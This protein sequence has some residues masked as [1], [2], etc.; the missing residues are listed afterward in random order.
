[1]F[2]LVIV[3]D[4]YEL[5]NGLR[6]Y[7]PWEEIGFAVG[8]VCGSGMAALEYIMHNQV[9]VLFTDIK[10]PQMDGIELIEKVKKISPA[11]RSVIISG[12][13]DF[14]YARKGMALGVSDFIVKPAKYAEIKQVFSQIAKEL[15]TREKFVTEPVVESGNR[16]IDA[17][18][19]Y[20]NA[21][22]HEA[23][24]ETAAMQVR[25]NPYYLSTLFHQITKEKFSACL[26]RIR[27]EKATELLSNTHLSIQEIAGKI[28]YA[29]ANSFSRMFR[30]Q[31]EISPKEYRNLHGPQA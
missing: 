9:D 10:M 4:E 12:Y 23:S 8:S 30:A 27:M 31:Y 20:L 25:L 3:D 17:V 5:R 2:N 15:E 18:L 24:L 26:V 1:M 13:R 29:N 14:E 22:Y 11:T 21:S 7:F 19:A 16:I 6:N 28:G